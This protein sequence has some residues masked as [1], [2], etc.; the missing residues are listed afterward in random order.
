MARPRA[1]AHAE[2]TVDRLLKAAEAEFARAGF[3]GARLADIATAAGIRRPS[4]LYH[5]PSKEALYAA[6]V[7]AAFER[8]GATVAAAI[9]APGD[10][11]A[12]LDA[13]T[14]SYEAFLAAEPAFAPLVLREIL[15]GRGPGR[16]LL[17]EVVPP[18][19]DRIEAFVAAEGGS[20]VRTDLLRAALLQVAA[21]P[22]VR[23]AAPEPLRR[24]VWGDDAAPIA[25]LARALI[26]PEA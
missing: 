10:F 25:R 7:R 14:E 20:A 26:L 15:D 22:L 17:Q 9:A 13:L 6:A 2:P 4:L 8:L 12:R 11:G 1:D 18:L 16:A 3:E 5:F 24:A 23:S 19:L 21:A